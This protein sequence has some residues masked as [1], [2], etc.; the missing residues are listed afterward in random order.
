MCNQSC[1]ISCW[2]SCTVEPRY[3][4]VNRNPVNRG[5]TLALITKSEIVMISLPQDCLLIEVLSPATPWPFHDYP[6]DAQ[7]PLK[8]VFQGTSHPPCSRGSRASLFLSRPGL[9]VSGGGGMW[10]NIH[11]ER[12][13]S[14]SLLRVTQPVSH[15]YISHLSFDRW[16]PL[17]VTK[18]EDPEEVHELVRGT[19]QEITILEKTSCLPNSKFLSV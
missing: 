9:I 2:K 10:S 14:F 15:N 18:S 3:I 17:Q 1:V 6:G 11:D 5:P 12:C 16:Q 7:Y 8:A 4:P 19:K 13:F